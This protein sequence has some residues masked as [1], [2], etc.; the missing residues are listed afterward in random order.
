MADKRTMSNGQLFGIVAEELERGNSTKVSVLGRS[1]RPFF[2][3]GQIIVLRPMIAEELRI[4]SVVLARIAPDHYA[5]HRII[6]ID[7]KGVTLMGDG[8]VVGRERVRQEDIYG[9]VECSPRHRRW[10]RLWR[11]LLPVRRYLLAIIALFE[12]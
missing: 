3:S 2:R 4:G 8:N 9:Y 11:K 7:S 5:V 1:M 12:S 6:E 10:A